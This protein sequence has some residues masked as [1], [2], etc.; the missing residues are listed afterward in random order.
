[1]AASNYLDGRQIRF[2][3]VGLRLTQAQLAAT[4]GVD[5]SL[6]SRIELGSV[7]CSIDTTVRLAE[8]LGLGLSDIVI[9]TPTAA[10]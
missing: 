10:A 4:V 6:I 3:R 9:T 5:Q 1:M 7:S 2:R 8:A